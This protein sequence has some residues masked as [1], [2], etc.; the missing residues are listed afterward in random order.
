MRQKGAFKLWTKNANKHDFM[1][2]FLNLCGNIT[3]SEINLWRNKTK[4]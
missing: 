2:T 4:V 3:M 1:K